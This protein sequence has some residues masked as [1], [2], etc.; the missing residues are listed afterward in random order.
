MGAVDGLALPG[1]QADFAYPA[2]GEEGFFFR[3]AAVAV[4]VGWGKLVM[5]HLSPILGHLPALII[6]VSLGS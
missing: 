1:A 3:K 5:V 4:D 6:I 2:M